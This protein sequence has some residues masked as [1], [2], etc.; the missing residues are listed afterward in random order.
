MSKKH[1]KK[2]RERWETFL[3]KIKQRY[4]DVLEEGYQGCLQLLDINNFDTIPWPMRGQVFQ[5]SCY[6]C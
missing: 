3:G 4:V 2:T 6:S 1:I 5:G